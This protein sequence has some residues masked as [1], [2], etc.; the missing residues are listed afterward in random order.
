MLILFHYITILIYQLLR[1]RKRIKCSHGGKEKYNHRIC[2]N[3]YMVNTRPE[4]QKYG[5]LFELLEDEGWKN[6]IEKLVDLGS[7]N[8]S[9]I[10]TL[11]EVANLNQILLVD[12]ND[13]LLRESISNLDP[14]VYLPHL[15]KR[16]KHLDISI[17]AGNAADSDYRLLRTDAITAVNLLESLY[18]DALDALPYNIFTFVEPK[19]VI[20][21]TTV[22]TSLSN[23][24]EKNRRSVWSRQQFEDW[25]N[26]MKIR[27]PDY[28]CHFQMI[29]TP[30]KTDFSWLQ[31]SE[32]SEVAL[33]LRRDLLDPKYIL[34][35]CST[36]CLCKLD[37]PCRIIS[38]SSKMLCRCVCPLCCPSSSFGVCKYHS[39]TKMAMTLEEDEDY[40]QENADFNI[41]Y[42]LVAHSVL[43]YE[44]NDIS[45]EEE[46]LDTDHQSR[47]QRGNRT[48][49]RAQTKHLEATE[50]LTERQLLNIILE[51]GYTFEECR[52]EEDWKA[53]HHYSECPTSSRTCDMEEITSNTEAPDY[54]SDRVKKPAQK[55][56]PSDWEENGEKKLSDDNESSSAAKD[57]SA[58][59][60]S[61]KGEA[62]DQKQD[63]LV[64]SGYQKSPS[65]IEDSPIDDLEET[66]LF[67]ET[68]STPSVDSDDNKV[69]LRRSS[70]SME[71]SH[72]PLQADFAKFKLDVNR[73]NEL[74][75]FH[76]M[77]PG[78]T[79]FN[80]MLKSQDAT[81]RSFLKERDLPG[82]SN[83]PLPARKRKK[84]KKPLGAESEEDSPFDD[85]KSITNCLIKNTLNRLEVND[86]DEQRNN[87]RDD[88]IE[89]NVEPE[90]A[91][92]E[93]VEV[94]EPEVVVV[95]V[96]AQEEAVLEPEVVQQQ[97][98]MQPAVV[99]V[100]P[101]GLVVENGDLA[102]N[103]RDIEGNNYIA[104]E[105]QEIAENDIENF[106]LIAMEDVPEV[107]LVQEI[108]N[109][110]EIADNNNHNGEDLQVIEDP[111]VLVRGVA[112][113]EN[114]Q[115]NA[116]QAEQDQPEPA[117]VARA[118]REALFD[119]NS[120][121]DLLE[122]VDVPSMQEQPSA[123]EDIGLVDV[124]EYG[125]N[126]VLIGVAPNPDDQDA[127]VDVNAFPRWLLQILGAQVAQNEEDGPQ[128]AS[129]EPH[130]YCQ[131]DGLGIHP[132][133]I[134]VD[135]D[136]DE[137][138][139]QS[140]NT[141]EYADV[142][143]EPSSQDASSLPEES[144]PLVEHGNNAEED[145]AVEPTTS[146][147]TEF[148]DSDTGEHTEGT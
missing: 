141:G 137:E 24:C 81:R 132:S 71:K 108:V 25:S 80:H 17:L 27:F 34:T 140:S 129:D 63:A 75:K 33:F 56:S 144:Q 22:S 124:I 64:D 43:P 59:E 21:I 146:Q 95:D 19:I 133:V 38:S 109:V 18:P 111:A 52:I 107:H 83:I 110:N 115:N 55:K 57:L 48:A 106:N 5:K 105:N 79:F 10:Y 49:E 40:P 128:D 15:S 120:E 145:V 46:G 97:D 30:K 58:P 82:P 86:S 116:Q 13:E 67:E 36:Q 47:E 69:H 73:I 117:G 94:Q 72:P 74:D 122:D 103:N 53:S 12:I 142:E 101:A 121:P 96:H 119:P 100:P 20:F 78:R 127:P 14:H 39:S 50:G 29:Q 118:S 60:T 130:F 147:Q 104:P 123:M 28:T 44:D 131:G 54:D 68:T 62:S 51:Q 138:S 45:D 2:N 26:N 65:P 92:V 139:T 32:I 3:L 70:A 89:F 1:H 99:E 16:Y 91:E 114:D 98:V 125:N 112:E 11:L 31:L 113:H 42:K 77:P 84:H 102:N 85:C 88:V 90:L 148:F 87:G 9:I 35:S 6:K 126:I 4:V 134:A 135:A 76:N 37:S 93:V 41:Y 7:G 8:L 61:N 136:E 143:Q 23:I 66:D